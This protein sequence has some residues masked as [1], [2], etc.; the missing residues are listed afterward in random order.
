MATPILLLN[1]G[2]SSI[3]YQMIDADT[4]EVM[5]SGLIERIGQDVGVLTH[6]VDGEEFVANEEYT[7][8]TLPWRRWCRCSPTTARRWPT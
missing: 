4:D 8:H 6:K 2:S 3:K 1:A 7:N 5:A